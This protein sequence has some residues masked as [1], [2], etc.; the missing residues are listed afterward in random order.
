VA[1]SSGTGVPLVVLDGLVLFGVLLTA[2]VVLRQMIEMRRALAMA[3]EAQ[4]SQQGLRDPLTG[5]ANRALFTNRVEHALE[6][7]A[8]YRQSV[9]VLFVD[10]DDF[11]AVNDKLGHAAG[12]QL[13]RAA[14]ARLLECV[15]SADTAA[16]IGGDEF[17]VLLEAAPSADEAPEVA[18][19]ILRAMRAPFRLD[20]QE[21]FVCA[22]IGIAVSSD[23]NE[24]VDDLL[25]QA[26]I[27][28]Y[29]AKSHGKN[30]SEIF[31]PEMNAA[32]HARAALRVDLE[33]A[34]E[35]EELSVYYQPTVALRTGTVAGL[36]ALVR[37]SHPERGLIP[38][39]EFLPLAE[40]T[41]LILPIGRWVLKRACQQASVWHA[42]Y[43]SDPPL[44]VNVNLSPKQL[45]H[46]CLVEEVADTIRETGLEPASLI[47]DISEHVLMED[48]DGAL[49]TLVALKSLGVRLAVDDFGSGFSSLSN[50]RRSP[51]D[52][53]KID[54]LF[55][56]GLSEGRAASALASAIIELG[57][58]LDL[59]VVA[60]GIEVSGQLEC[61]R[62]LGCEMG[63]GY[64]FA[65]P[66]PK[67]AVS[68]MIAASRPPAAAPRPETGGAAA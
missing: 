32:L 37:W 3:L 63:Q 11:K 42:Q 56:E 59:Q 6:R 14:A 64:F 34:L 22:S 27:A 67:E 1:A 31:L 28:M 55:V 26:D 13:L 57:R 49:G 36:E 35:R 7:R 45:Q 43:P 62:D 38:A 18:E 40:E 20:S 19:R 52:I 39:T 25:R 68:A 15:R 51:I 65:R 17:A 54:K 21:H 44:E 58:A 61:L 50:L 16:R 48:G 66:L 12:D 41:G 10:L 5:L 24:T 23:S 8:R 46:P 30:R 2:L 53:L 60:E 4:L 9:A 33:R 47:L 29:A